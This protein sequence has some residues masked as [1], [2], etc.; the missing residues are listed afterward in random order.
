MDKLLIIKALFEIIWK[1]LSDRD[2][3]GRPDLFDSK[4]DDAGQK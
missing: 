4:P 1:I 2:G 3:D